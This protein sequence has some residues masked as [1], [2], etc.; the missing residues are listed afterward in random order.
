M[1][2]LKPWLYNKISMLKYTVES[3]EF[4]QNFSA[5]YGQTFGVL[6][7]VRTGS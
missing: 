2:Y 7:S 6:N 5:S 1:A 4:Y 3:F